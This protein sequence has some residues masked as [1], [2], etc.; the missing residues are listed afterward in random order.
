MQ[1]EPGLL[2]DPREG[3]LEGPPVQRAAIRLS[4]DVLGQLGQAPGQLR[5]GLGLPVA[6]PEIRELR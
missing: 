5:L 4:E 6:T 3:P 2:E 1:T